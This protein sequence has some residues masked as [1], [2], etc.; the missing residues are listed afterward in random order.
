M[1]RA[2]LVPPVLAPGA[3][4]E[5]KNWLAISTAQDDLT[6]LALLGSALDTCEAFTR[7]FPLMVEAE[8][9]LP[10]S[11]AWQGLS[12][13]PVQAITQV[14]ELRPDGSRT[15]LAAGAYALELE[16]GGAA[17]LRLLSPAVTGRLAVR[18]TAGLAADWDT[19]PDGLRH[20]VIRLAAHHYRQRDNADANPAPPAAVA[21]LWSPWRRMRLI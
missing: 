9:I 2:I 5:L 8:E 1:K 6:L 7:T 3:L 11:R 12:S 18:I 21:A 19:L 13:N 20:G 14:E 10:P 4:A 15:V 16:A 17:R